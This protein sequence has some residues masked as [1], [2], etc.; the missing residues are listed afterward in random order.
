[1]RFAGET[2]AWVKEELEKKDI[3]SFVEVVFI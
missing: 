2:V 1:M 3:P